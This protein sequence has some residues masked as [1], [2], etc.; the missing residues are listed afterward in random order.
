MIGKLNTKNIVFVDE[1]QTRVPKDYDRVHD[2]FITSVS[3]VRGV[4]AIYQF[5]EVSVYGMSD[6]DY[7]VCVNDDIDSKEFIKT[8]RDCISRDPYILMH[9]PIVIH[10][11]LFSKINYFIPASDLRCVWGKRLKRGFQSDEMKTLMLIDVVN[12][13]Y[14]KEL[15]KVFL[16]KSL[17]SSRGTVP[18]LVNDLAKLLN[19]PASNRVVQCRTLLSR[20]NALKY[21]L[22]MIEDL[23]GTCDEYWIKYIHEVDELRKGWLTYP[24]D[25]RRTTLLQSVDEGIDCVNYIISSLNDYLR[26]KLDVVASQPIIMFERENA[27][28]YVHPWA[29]NLSLERTQQLFKRTNEVFSVLPMKFA[30]TLLPRG[31]RRGV[32]N[33]HST[34]LENVLITKTQVIKSNTSFLN[35]HGIF[36]HNTLYMFDYPFTNKFSRYLKM[37]KFVRRLKCGSI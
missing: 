29:K 36:F 22:G 18:Y 37:N 17:T 21:P 5:G 2:C 23:T 30:A 26:D 16:R 6:L 27:N 35:R 12:N 15:M 33:F 31:D 19:I 24:I 4:S 3:A 9:Y 32:I 11:S 25:D 14:P 7:L 1:P 8:I 13:H 10:D 28:L 34:D 20:L